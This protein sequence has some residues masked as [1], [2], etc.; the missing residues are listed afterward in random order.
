MDKLHK[1]STRCHSLA[2]AYLATVLED[3]YVTDE[4]KEDSKI[5]LIIFIDTCEFSLNHP[6]IDAPV[7]NFL[8]ADASG[9]PALLIHLCVVL[10]EIQ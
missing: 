3:V 1:K 7:E 2:T 9:L 6:F 8:T 10:G 5:K 4:L